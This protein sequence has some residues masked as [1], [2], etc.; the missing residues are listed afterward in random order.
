MSNTRK[1]P[2]FFLSNRL[3]VVL[4]TQCIIV[5]KQPCVG[6]AGKLAIYFVIKLRNSHQTVSS[7]GATHNKGAKGVA[8]E[9][10]V[11]LE[12]HQTAKRQVFSV[13]SRIIFSTF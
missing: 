8:K 7:H 11:V 10:D 5:A 13:L 9:K 3:P 1:R 6:R 4:S 12:A 2:P